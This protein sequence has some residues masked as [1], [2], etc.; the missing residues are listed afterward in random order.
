[1]GLNL[2]Y[3]SEQSSLQNKAIRTLGG[4]KYFDIVTPIYSKLKIL[5][6]PDL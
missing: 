4:S 1:M 6:L 3:V 5:K 2:P